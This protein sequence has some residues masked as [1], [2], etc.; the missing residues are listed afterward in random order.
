MLTLNTNNYRCSKTDAQTAFA[1]KK[2][3]EG[4]QA[5]HT[6][7]QQNWQK[8]QDRK[9]QEAQTQKL[10]T[11]WTEFQDKF[12]PYTAPGMQKAA[13]QM[14]DAI[15]AQVHLNK[16]RTEGARQRYEESGAL[17]KAKA[18]LLSVKSKLGIK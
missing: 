5:A 1:G 17:D 11:E 16:M 7:Q 6:V 10:L 3:Q 18:G 12:T 14:T 9:K 13:S 15:Q 2:K 4:A 8:L